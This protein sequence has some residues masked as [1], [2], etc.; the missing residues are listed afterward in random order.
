MNF[1]EWWYDFKIKNRGR[2]PERALVE[3]AW[4]AARIGCQADAKRYQLLRSL[5]WIDVGG[6]VWKFTDVRATGGTLDSAVD[7]IENHT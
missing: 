1:A 7:A 3:A 2:I 4:A 5:A 6:E